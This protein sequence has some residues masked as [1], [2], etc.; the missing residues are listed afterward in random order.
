MTSSSRHAVVDGV[1]RSGPITLPF[2]RLEADMLRTPVQL[3]FI[4]VLLLQSTA[5]AAQEQKVGE[6]VDAYIDQRFEAGADATSV[7]LQQLAGM[8]VNTLPDLETA[9]RARR[10]SYPDT[11][12]LMEKYSVHDVECYHV[13]YSSKFLLYVPQ[14]LAGDLPLSVVVVGHGGNSSMSPER[15]ESVAAMYLREYAPSVSRECKALVVAPVSGRGWGHIGNSLILSTISKLQRMFPVDPDRIYITGQSMGGHLSFRAALSLPDRFGAVSPHS[16]GY[17]FVEKGSIGNLLSV[18]GYAI[19]GSTEP[20][21]I[22]TDNRTNAG[23]GRQHGLDWKFVEKNGGHTIYQDELPAMARF[24]NDHPRDLYRDSVY[25]QQGGEMKF[26]KTWEIEGWPR[27]IVYSGERPLRWNLRQWIEVAPR[28]DS[29]EPQTLLARN[30]GNNHFEI[31]SQN[32]RNLK[33]LLHPQ[34]IDFSQPVVVTANGKKIFESVVT[35]DPAFMF[36]LV[37]EFDDRGRIF[38]AAAELAID[39]DHSVDIPAVD[40]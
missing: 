39:T 21:G 5:V 15:A 1:E 16:G 37:R 29:T 25:M 3:I 22:N 36:E 33:L 23:W 28:I 24:F 38:W 14:H 35:P 8:G 27:H 26:V 9:L 18:P 20:Y 13:D 10:A 34:M 2:A 6:L 30:S 12:G 17:D 32:V 7:L 19:W 4:A 40:E 31:T 11:Q